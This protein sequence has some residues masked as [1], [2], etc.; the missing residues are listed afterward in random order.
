MTFQSLGKIINKN[1]KKTG[2][3]K[4]IEIAMALEKFHYVI[5]E[6]WGDKIL[7]KANGISIKNKT[8]TVAV[9]SSV[10]AQEINLKEGVIIDKINSYFNKEV[11]NKICIQ[12]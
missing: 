12:I 3:S 7:E 9:L 2:L 1:V 11:V 6:I 10:V 8:L 5:K 4:Q